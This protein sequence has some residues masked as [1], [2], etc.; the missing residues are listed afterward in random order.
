MLTK[1]FAMAA[2]AA[3]TLHLS[4][5]H[6]DNQS[7]SKPDQPSSQSK[8]NDKIIYVPME[9]DQTDI[10]AIPLDE[11]DFEQEQELY[12]LQHPKSPTNK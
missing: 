2:I 9:P 4:V 6:A 12:N 8:T 11:D 7:E 5:L 3:S 1:I 10:F